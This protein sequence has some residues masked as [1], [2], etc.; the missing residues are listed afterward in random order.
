MIFIGIL[1]LSL[2]VTAPGMVW[3]SSV[4]SPHRYLRHD[5]ANTRR[6]LTA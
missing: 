6:I 3:R 4:A 1:H 5:G 2:T